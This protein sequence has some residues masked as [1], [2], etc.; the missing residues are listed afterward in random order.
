MP[1]PLELMITELGNRGVAT[2]GSS[3]SGGTVRLLPSER[4]RSLGCHLMGTLET[5][6]KEF[7]VQLALSIRC[8][9]ELFL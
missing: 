9:C 7:K 8:K 1:N 5:D 6:T 3:S 2:K 4:W